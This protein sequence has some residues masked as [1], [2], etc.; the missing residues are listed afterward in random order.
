MIP[1]GAVR[2]S[3]HHVWVKTPHVPIEHQGFLAW[4]LE[5]P[6]GWMGLVTW[7]DQ[8]GEPVGPQWIP[9]SWIR[10]ERSHARHAGTAYAPHA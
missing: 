6:D 1:E 3:T 5:S 2:P 4:W 7:V 8:T 10:P 9:A